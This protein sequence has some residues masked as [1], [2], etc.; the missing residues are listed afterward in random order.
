MPNAKGKVFFSGIMQDMQNTTISLLIDIIS[1]LNKKA[2]PS[3]KSLIRHSKLSPKMPH[4]RP[5]C[6]ALCE[7]KRCALDPD[8]EAFFKKEQEYF[9]S[10]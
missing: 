2:R 9:S 8:L 4:C 10:D 6:A 7:A 5:S 1:F 3:V